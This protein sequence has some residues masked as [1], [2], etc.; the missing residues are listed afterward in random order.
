MVRISGAASVLCMV[1][2]VGCGDDDGKAKKL[3]PGDKAALEASAEARAVLAEKRRAD[4][5]AEP[6]DEAPRRDRGG[7]PADTQ[8][9]GNPPPDGNEEYCVQTQTQGPP[10]RVGPYRRWSSAG[11]L[12]LEGTYVAGKKHGIWIEYHPNGRRKNRSEYRD[13]Q[14]DGSWESWFESGEQQG[15]G[16]YRE[17]KKHGAARFWHEN[18]QL[19]AES[20]YEEDL[21]QGKST[22]WY[23]NGKV[24]SQGSYVDGKKDGPW[25]DYTP[26][27]QTIRSTYK[28]GVKTP[29]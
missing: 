24:Q 22:N 1:M 28:D 21:R 4:E 17:G 27:G 10:L 23:E 15:E 25:V 18:G 16:S 12:A 3:R 14:L 8:R 9:I 2:L 6:E 7:C 29:G 5:E 20:E 19:K 11:E 13:D 26:D